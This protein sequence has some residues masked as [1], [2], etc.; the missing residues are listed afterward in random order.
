MNRFRITS[1]M[2]V[3]CA[4]VMTGCTGNVPSIKFPTLN[5]LGTIIP[6]ITPT[7]T[8]APT[9]TNTPSP[10][11]PATP[12]IRI[13][14]NDARDRKVI[15][16][17][18]WVDARAKIID[19][20]AL[21]YN[22]SNPYDIQVEP[23]HWGGPDALLDA[24]TGEI[25]NP[26]ALV[27]LP[28]EVR[29]GLTESGWAY[30]DLLPLIEEPEPAVGFPYLDDYTEPV[31]MPMRNGQ[32]LFGLPA[33]GD[34]WVLAYNQTWGRILGFENPPA[35]WQEFI[36]QS[37]EAAKTNNQLSGVHG[38]GGWLVDPSPDSILAWMHA[39]DAPIPFTSEET[40]RFFNPDY[41]TVFEN[42]RAIHE[43]GC[44]WFGR[45]PSPDLYFSD[46]LALFVSIRVSDIPEFA[47]SLSTAKVTD[48]WLI[49]PYPGPQTP[50]TWLADYSYYSIV[51][52][53]PKDQLAAW[54]FL[55]WLIEPE[56]ELRLALSDGRLPGRQ[57]TWDV[58][59]RSGKI[60][61]Q[62]TRWMSNVDGMRPY[63]FQPGWL[64]GKAILGDG[65]R[66]ILKTS[67]TVD[68]IP[69]ILQQMDTF[70]QVMESQP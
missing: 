12:E 65:I 32:Q 28:P 27:V 15:F 41:Q 57:L 66:Q 47:T 18:P 26:P 39:F 46:R 70:S 63:P 16:W 4:A 19:Q 44:T 21:E 48:Q 33:A 43:K 8:V 50:S 22:L 51:A 45:N 60:P 37:C 9:I 2:I 49:I 11:L 34:A 5:S 40:T 7:I 13:D 68:N 53:E 64:L 25:S 24:M 62:Q 54:L 29:N 6:T 38:T 1:V 59:A 67:S 69:A 36:A 58:M 23:R 10:T 61:V 20:L 30:L 42:L 56:R 3:L 14:P 55:R 52:R 17:H 35:N 31:L